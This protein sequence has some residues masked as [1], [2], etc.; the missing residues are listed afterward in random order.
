VVEAPFHRIAIAVSKR[1][2]A[3]LPAAPLAAQDS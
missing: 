2:K 3:P 1:L